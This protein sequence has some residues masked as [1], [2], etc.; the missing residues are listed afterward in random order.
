MKTKRK[1]KF[2]E[3]P[4]IEKVGGVELINFSK[5]IEEEMKNPEFRKGVE[6][7]KKKLEIS[8]AIIELRKKNK[9]SQAKLAQKAG[10]KQSAI[11]RIEAGKQNLTI[12]TL[13]QI[14]SAFNKKLE[15]GFR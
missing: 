13:Q 10:V 4:P 7:E 12:E 9:I 1:N 2:L 6:I 8:L 14:A 15:V 11:G 3:N 5:I